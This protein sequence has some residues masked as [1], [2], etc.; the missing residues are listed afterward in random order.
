MSYCAI[1]VWLIVGIIGIRLLPFLLLFSP[2]IIA[3]VGF[4]WFLGVIP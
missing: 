3:G 1:L 4:L 2:W